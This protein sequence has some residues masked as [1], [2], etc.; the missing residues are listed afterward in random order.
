ME[1]ITLAIAIIGSIL[2]VTTFFN[3]KKDKSTSE[4]KDFNMSYGLFM[5]E[6]KSELKHIKDSLEEIKEDIKTTD[7]KIKIAIE[8]HERIYH[9]GKN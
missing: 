2:A 5:G 7:S 8:N 4:T 3:N 1:Y 6:I 9:N